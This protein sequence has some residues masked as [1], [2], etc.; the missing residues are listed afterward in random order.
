[1]ECLYKEVEE[2]MFPLDEPCEEMGSKSFEVPALRDEE[3]AQITVLGLFVSFPNGEALSFVLKLDSTGF[4]M[5]IHL[6]PT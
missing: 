1:M 5:G 3:F 2:K 6:R 4:L